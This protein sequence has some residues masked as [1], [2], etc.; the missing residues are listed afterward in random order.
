MG[1]VGSLRHEPQVMAHGRSRWTPKKICASSASGSSVR[2]PPHQAAS[3]SLDSKCS[4][5]NERST[6]LWT[7][8]M[9]TLARCLMYRSTA[10]SSTD[11]AEALDS[12]I[13][14]IGPLPSFHRRKPSASFSV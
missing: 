1:F 5:Y 4:V 6:G 11:P 8:L 3:M 13:K 9:P 7:A 10:S 14:L 2:S 12:M